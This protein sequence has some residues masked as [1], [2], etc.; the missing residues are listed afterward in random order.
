MTVIVEV[1]DDRVWTVAQTMRSEKR[2]RFK[3]SLGDR[4]K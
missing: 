1:K 2:K 3:R 4:M